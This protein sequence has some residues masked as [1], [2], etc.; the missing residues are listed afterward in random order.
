MLIH[1]IA[2][3]GPADL[4][5]AEVVQRIRLLVPEAG[6]WATSVPPFATLAAG[7]CSAQLALNEAPAGTVVFTNVAPR[8]DDT[9]ARPDNA[10]EGLAC[11]EL[12][13]GVRVVGVNSGHTFSFLAP[14]AESFRH[15]RVANDGSQFRSRDNYPAALARLLRGDGDI[16]GDDVAADAVPPVPP[17]HV[18]YVDGFGNIK[19]TIEASRPLPAGE[20]VPV[21]I[22]GVT[23]TARVAGAGFAVPA[24]ELALSVGSSG[25]SD[26]HGGRL[27]YRELFLRG[28]SAW[29][30]F[31]R[32]AP[33]SAITMTG[34]P[35][36]PVCQ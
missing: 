11:L 30:E 5:F 31:G 8:R 3:F 26:G 18:A 14:H 22:G 4:A 16:L 34:G 29:D 32:P 12:A 19:T 10:G 6:V 21:T 15:V 25:W 24:G 7:F 35:G 28:G 33:E 17:A 9:S 27:R 2:D 23:R 20:C 1:L 13:G 36:D